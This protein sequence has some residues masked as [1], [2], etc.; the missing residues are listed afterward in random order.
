[1]GE[2]SA[3][4]RRKSSENIGTIVPRKLSQENNLSKFGRHVWLCADGVKPGDWLAARIRQQGG[5]CTERHANLIIEGKRK[6]NARAAL[7]VYAEI[8]G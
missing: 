1:M 7:A 3:R 6:P 5:K 4:R 2:S 8:I